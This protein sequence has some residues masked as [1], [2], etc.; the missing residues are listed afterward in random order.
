LSIVNTLHEHGQ[1]VR[2][3]ARN[4][5]RTRAVLPAGIDVV[6]GSFNIVAPG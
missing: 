4:V 5:D 1:R 3:M 6:A 2:A